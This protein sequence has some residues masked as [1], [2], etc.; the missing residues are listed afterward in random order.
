MIQEKDH[1]ELLKNVKVNLIINFMQLNKLNNIMDKLI[2]LKYKLFNKLK[3]IIMF[4][5]IM[6]LIIDNQNN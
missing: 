2:L 5:N 3:I 4:Y 6:I 1:L